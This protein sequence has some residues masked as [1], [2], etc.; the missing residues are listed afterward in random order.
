M[1][2]QNVAVSD[3]ELNE[4]EQ[5]MI[6]NNSADNTSDVGGVAGKRLLSFIE[7]VERMEE[8]KTEVMQDIKEIYAEAKATGFDTKILKQIVKLR[9]MDIE[10]RREADELLELYKTAVGMA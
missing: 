10:K 3:S 5:A 6:I 9:K 1:T 4:D 8:E 2:N 7:R